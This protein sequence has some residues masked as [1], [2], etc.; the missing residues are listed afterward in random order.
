LISASQT[1]DPT[2]SWYNYNSNARLNGTQNTSNWADFPG[3][4]FDNEAAYITSNQ[5]NFGGGGYYAKL[6]IFSKSQ[7]YAG[8]SLTYTDFWDMRDANG[9]IVFTLKPAHHFG[10]PTSR[11]LVNTGFGGGDYLTLWRV[12]NPI[13][14]SPTLTRQGTVSVGSYSLTPNAVQ[15]GSNNLI[16]TGYCDT[17]DAMYRGGYIY[18]TFSTAYNWGSGTVSAVRYAK[19]NVSTNTAALDVVYGNDG[20]YYY[21]PAI[22][23]DAAGNLV[24]VFSRSGTTEYAGVR[25]AYRYH[26]DAA[27]HPSE[28]LKSGEGPYFVD[29]GTGRNR[30]GDYS[31]IAL[32]PTDDRLIWFYGEWARNNNTWSTWVGSFKTTI[33]TTFTN[34][35]NSQNAGGTLRINSSFDVPSGQAFDLPENSSNTART[36]NERFPNW[37]GS[38]ITYKHHHWNDALTEYRLN[39]DFTA[40]SGA[41][42]NQKAIFTRLDPITV[43]TSLIEGGT[44]GSIQFRDPW[45][46]DPATGGQP[47]IYRTFTSP[48]DSGVF[49]GQPI[50]GGR[51]YYSVGAPNPN[52]INGIE[53]YFQ[54]WTGT[55]VQ[56][57]NAGADQTAVVFQQ[58]NATAMTVYKAHLLS[59]SGNATNSTSQRKLG[60]DLAFGPYNT[61]TYYTVYESHGEIWLTHAGTSPGFG[62]FRVSDGSG[63]FSAPSIAVECINCSGSQNEG[64]TSIPQRLEIYITYRKQVGSSYNVISRVR[65]S[66]AS[67]ALFWQEPVM[68]TPTP[69]SVDVRPVIGKYHRFGDSDKL[70]A[71]WE[72]F[73]GLFYAEAER[74]A[75]D[76]W[77]WSYQGAL[78]PGPGFARPSLSNTHGTYDQKLYLSFEYDS[79]IFM[80]PHGGLLQQVSD[81]PVFINNRNSSIAVDA[82]GRVHVTWIA[83]DKSRDMEVVV[84]R[85]Y[86]NDEPSPYYLVINDLGENW[87]LQTSVCAHND[88][89]NG[90]VSVFWTDGSIPFVF[91][92]YS[93]D[94]YNFNGWKYTAFNGISNYPNAGARVTPTTSSFVATQG[95]QSLYPIVFGSNDDSDGSWSGPS[96][97]TSNRKSKLY[98]RAFFTDTTTHASLSLEFGD[99]IL[100]GVRDTLNDQ[101]RFVDTRT[102]LRG[103]FLRTEAFRVSEPARAHL[104]IAADADL[105]PQAAIVSLVVVDSATGNVIATLSTTQ[106]SRNRKNAIKKSIN[107]QLPAF[108]HSAYLELHIAGVALTHYKAGFAN[109]EAVQRGAATQPTLLVSKAGANSQVKQIPTSFEFHPSYP[110]PFNPSTTITFDL[111][112]NSNVS[113]VVYDVLGRKVAELENGMKEAGYHATTWNAADVAS[114]FYFARFAARDANGSVKL[115]KV[116]KLLLTK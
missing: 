13:G 75:Q 104:R 33:P 24:L 55:N 80:S 103:T 32:D 110:N 34:E 105:L 94:G 96:S 78:Y 102:N 100:T 10:T 36:L 2:G 107:E 82:T 30:W 66:T 116:S 63:G 18:T 57:Q 3:L 8:Q 93:W 67:G 21:Y 9:D 15:Q 61:D 115:A 95:S 90:G 60:V 37:Q 27:T 86:Y 14:G 108:D 43:N 65:S 44:G 46:V 68:L 114:G 47:N 87:N 20:L 38:G 111:P 31:G 4:G 112:E 39:H 81:D 109:I 48:M 53:S 91:D 62:E 17:Q 35:I 59:S 76:S 85:S 26:F 83:Y 54:Y 74:N 50:I 106:L 40:T 29:Y 56:F 51:P 92:N 16:E 88:P 72:S 84:H 89:N 79:E 42:Q 11:Y 98:R 70:L 25:Y 28:N 99:I 101:V 97:P 41:A 12:D 49:L 64:G 71:V 22:Y 58:P 69:V 23:A 7:L 113:L 77:V 45:W 5:I 19:I 73:D 1:S 52:Y 6:R